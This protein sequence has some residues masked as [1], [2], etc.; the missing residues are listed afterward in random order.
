M[1]A[2]KEVTS[3]EDEVMHVTGVTNGQK[4]GVREEV[5]SKDLP[6]SKI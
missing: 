6:T 5:G 2:H 1:G 3:P 4:E